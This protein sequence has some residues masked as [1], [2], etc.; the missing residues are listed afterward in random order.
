ML[1]TIEWP[2]FQVEEIRGWIDKVNEHVEEIKLLNSKILSSPRPEDR[3]Y[4]FLNL[5]PISVK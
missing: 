5:S 2:P 3:K 1:L 4:F